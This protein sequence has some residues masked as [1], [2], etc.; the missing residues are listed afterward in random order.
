VWKA[1]LIAEAADYTPP[2]PRPE[3]TV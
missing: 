2:L 1:L 3:V